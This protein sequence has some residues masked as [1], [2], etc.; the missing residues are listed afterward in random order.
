LLDEKHAL[1]LVSVMLF[2]G[3][4]VSPCFAFG[5]LVGLAFGGCDKKRSDA[6]VTA[7]EHIDVAEIKPSPTPMPTADAAKL[8]PTP[9]PEGEEVVLKEMAPD[10]IAVDGFVMKKEVRGTSKDPR[11]GHD[12]QWRI[13]VDIVEARRSHTIHSDRAHYDK[14]KI[15]DRVKVRY[16]QGQYTGAVWTA[17]L[18]D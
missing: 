8:Q 11:A 3:T 7:K 18:E 15:G 5:A 4:I 10:E 16:R 13:T 14:L 1:G 17:D 6:I 9:S 12:E 2:R